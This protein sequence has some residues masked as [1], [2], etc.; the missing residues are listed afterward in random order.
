MNAVFMSAS[1]FNPWAI[2]RSCRSSSSVRASLLE[3]Q[4]STSPTITQAGIV[5]AT[6]L[7]PVSTSPARKK[8]GTRYATIAS[9]AAAS[10]VQGPCASPIQTNATTKKTPYV[11]SLPA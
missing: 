11:C 6:E 4:D 7:T 8:N 1:S 10:E 5:T 2:S 9:G 3:P